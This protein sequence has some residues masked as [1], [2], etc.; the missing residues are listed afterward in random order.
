MTP[1]RGLWPFPWRLA[2]STGVIPT[3]RIF[4]SAPSGTPQLFGTAP[5][6]G[7]GRLFETP[8]EATGTPRVFKI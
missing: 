2:G 7:T 3:L 5:D 4:G 1:W 8:V 6:S